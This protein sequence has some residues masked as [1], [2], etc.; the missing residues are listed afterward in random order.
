MTS[1]IH[2]RRGNRG[3]L[4]RSLSGLVAATLT[5]TLAVV[6]LSAGEA[7]AAA[8]TAVAQ[9]SPTRLVQSTGNLY[10]TS[11]YID[12]FGPDF[13]GVYRTGKTSTPGQEILL[14]GESSDAVG[15]FYFGGLTYALVNGVWYGYFTANYVTQGFTQIKRIPL[16]GGAATVLATAPALAG[17][18][19]LV[20]DGSFLYWADAAGVRKMSVAGG[21]IT[22]LATGT[23]LLRVGL[24]ATQVYFTAGTALKSVPKAGGAVTQQFTTASTMQALFVRPAT[25]SGTVIYWGEANDS[26]S[27]RP[28]GG[29]VS[30]YQAATSGRQAI[31]VSFDGTRVLWTDSNLG[32]SAYGV[33]KWQAGVTTVVAS[34]EVGS[35]EV[36]G[37]ATAMFWGNVSGVRRYNH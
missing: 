27:S 25:A 32:G 24:D 21:A 31:S 11:D 8:P 3:P 1:T 35:T 36:Q 14:Y 37:D 34:G 29:A 28:I 5:A 33:R 7:L 9:E 4:V 18:R 20:T 2:P 23:N 15:Y 17:A 19:D 16:A 12:E 13:A 22:T 30:T 10:W 6:G 26:V